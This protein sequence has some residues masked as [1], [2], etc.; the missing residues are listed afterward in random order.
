MRGLTFVELNNSISMFSLS[1]ICILDKQDS[2]PLSFKTK[3][4]SVYS[5]LSLWFDHVEI[6]RFTASLLYVQYHFPKYFRDVPNHQRYNIIFR[7]I[8]PKSPENGIIYS[9]DSC[10]LH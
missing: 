2:H 4:V 3:L 7:N 1:V 10:E 6:H 9:L 5:C 8:G